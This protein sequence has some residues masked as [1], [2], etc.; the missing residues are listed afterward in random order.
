MIGQT[1]GSVCSHAKPFALS[2]FF[3]TSFML[4]IWTWTRNHRQHHKYTDT[5]ADPH[6]ADRGFFY[7]HIGWILYPKHPE[8]KA[9]HR[10]IDVRDVMADP[11][12]RFQFRH[13]LK[14]VA[15]IGFVLPTALPVLLWGESWLYAFA[16]CVGFRHCLSTHNICLINSAAH[17]YGTKPYNRKLMPS[18]NLFVT[19][20]SLGE[21]KFYT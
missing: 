16:L 1:M 4:S 17:L 20:L 2:N 9:K 6:N 18:E 5:D 7:S 14:L 8:C 21:G 10:T 12:A 13:Y 11:V 15:L 19:Y 3:L